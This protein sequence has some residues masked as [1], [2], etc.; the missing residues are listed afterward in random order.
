QRR[1]CDAGPLARLRRSMAGARRRA[2]EILR[3]L[4]P[5]LRSRGRGRGVRHDHPEDVPEGPVPRMSFGTMAAWQAL[6]LVAVAAAAAWLLFRIKVRPPKVQV[7]TL[8][9]WRKVFDHA[10]EMTWWERIRRVVSLVAT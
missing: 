4:Q 2:R 3:P 1:R 8:L 6:L 5:G 10:R 7:P 9:L